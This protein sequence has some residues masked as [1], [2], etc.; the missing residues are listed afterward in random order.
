MAEFNAGLIDQVEYFAL[1]RNLTREQATKFVA[2]MKATD[3]MKEVSS[4]MNSF[5]I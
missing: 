1:T 5:G 2:E 4:L 3:T